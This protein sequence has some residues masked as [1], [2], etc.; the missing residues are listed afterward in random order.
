VRLVRAG[1]HLVEVHIRRSRRARRL[2]LWAPPRRP[3]ELVVPWRVPARSVE[4]F[5]AASEP[6]LE[7]RAAEADAPGA[8]GLERPG[9]VWH[10]GDPLPI[11][12]RVAAGSRAAAALRND[13]LVVSAA[14][15]DEALAAIDR[16]YRREARA[17]LEQA[18]REEAPLLGVQ[19]ARIAVR[20]TT[21]RFGSCSTS[22]TVSF[23]WRLVMTP[24]A[25]LDYVVIHELCHLREANHGKGFWSLVEAARPDWRQHRD[26]LHEHGREL[27]AYAPDLG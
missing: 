10:G 11:D 18:V 25:V 3:L 16:W 7:A 27:L 21:S 23:S 2:R 5:L 6:W 22:G 4:D 9:V 24:P 14:G 20:D 12:L 8:L 13:V 26:W 17:A 15:V 1:D 19:P